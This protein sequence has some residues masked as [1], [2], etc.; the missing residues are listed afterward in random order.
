MEAVTS[1]RYNCTTVSP[2]RLPVFL[3]VTLAVRVPPGFNVFD[4]SVT[5]DRLKS[6]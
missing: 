2:S 6:V 5:G 3:T 4:D 1:R